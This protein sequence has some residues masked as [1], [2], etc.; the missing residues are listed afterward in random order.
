MIRN[1]QG[2]AL[3][4]ASGKIAH[5]KVN[6]ALIGRGWEVRDEVHYE[7]W[8]KINLGR[9]DI[10]IMTTDAEGN[11]IVI[12]VKG[13]GAAGGTAF[14]KIA[15]YPDYVR[16]QRLIGDRSRQFWCVCVPTESGAYRNSD[17]DQAV[18]AAEW[19]LEQQVKSGAI[20]EGVCR[21]LHYAD[22]LQLIEGQ[23]P[24]KPRRPPLF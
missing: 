12:E 19:N 1:G 7:K 8:D 2:G 24:R 9:R 23:E 18:R 6:A 3:T 15:Y 21:V 16:N 5:R 17:V 14:D 22:F 13:Y 20:P 10:T 11:Q 4:T